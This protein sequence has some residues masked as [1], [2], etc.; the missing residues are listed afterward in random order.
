MDT[1][2]AQR[3]LAEGD[4]SAA[5][6]LWPLVYDELHALAESHFRRLPG[7]QTLQP[8]AL[9]HEA[10]LRL[11]NR[12]A[13]SVRDR[14]HFMAIAA[15]AMRQIL[16]DHAR[17]RGAEKRGGGATR[18]SLEEIDLPGAQEDAFDVTSIHSAL[19][20][21][22]VMDARKAMIVELRFFGGLTTEETAIALGVSRT[23]V[24]E[25]WRFARAWMVHELQRESRP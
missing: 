15:K 21:L 17:R 14:A 20:R 22:A 16:V 13:D 3:E 12:P 11:V 18:V 6:R 2:V 25:E 5:E 23:T 7:G 24:T 1:A 9:V 8:T 19:E 4:A 10:F